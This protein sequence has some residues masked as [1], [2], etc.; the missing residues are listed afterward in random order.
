MAVLRD[1]EVVH[2]DGVVADRLVQPS[3][4]VGKRLPAHC[5]ALGKVLL[6]CAPKGLQETYDRQVIATER[7]EGRTPTTLTDPAKLLEHLRMVG[8][9]GYAVD[10]ACAAAPVFDAAGRLAAALSV[11]GPSFRLGAERVASRIAPL[12]VAVAERLS[13]GLGYPGS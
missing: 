2:L 3:L 4:R 5:T 7:L 12:V 8:G 9:Q 13:Q 11:S 1:F 6:G 10:V